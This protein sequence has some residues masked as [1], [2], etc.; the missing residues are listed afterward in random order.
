MYTLIAENQY[1]EQLELTHNE[2]YVIESIEG[3]DPPEATINTTKNVNADGSVFNSSYANNRQIII[4]LAVNGPAET[5]RIN[6]YKY[7]KSKYPV[8]LYYKNGSRDVSIDGHV[9]KIQIEFFNKKQIAQITVICPN[10]Y[11]NG[12]G[13][14]SFDFTPVVSRFEFP[15]SIETPIPFSDI[16]IGRE[17][18][19]VN[20]GDVESGAVFTIHARGRVINPTIY[21]INLN[22]YFGVQITM[23]R[24]D[25]VVINTRK[26]EKSVTLI[27]D[28][29]KSNVVGK[30]R[31]G[32][33]WIQL[34]PGN[35]LLTATVDAGIEFLDVSCELIDRYEGV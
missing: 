30:M 8:K 9:K 16:Y 15:F 19:E 6:L 21:N 1:G 26:K 10:P 20:N 5:N 12:D 23:S 34:Q 27:S 13:Q 11:F 17:E 33:S 2:A 31:Q 14:S 35:N 22:Q 32:S 28:G 18:N 25:V 29:V 24:G 4:T 7:F 3:I